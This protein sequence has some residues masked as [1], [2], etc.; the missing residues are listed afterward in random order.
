MGDI[1]SL[2]TMFGVYAVI[3]L[4]GIFLYSRLSPNVE[5]PAISQGDDAPQMSSRDRKL[6]IKMTAVSALDAL[7]GGFIVRCESLQVWARMAV[8]REIKAV[9]S[10]PDVVVTAK[11]PMSIIIA[12]LDAQGRRTPP[13]TIMIAMMTRRRRRPITS[14]FQLAIRLDKALP[15]M[16]PLNTSPAWK[17]L[18]P[19]WLR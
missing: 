16:M 14:P 3:A 19:N 5:P 2:K 15:A 10:P 13:N 8:S 7:G 12:T 18:N 6:I 11:R 17:T 4:A 9:R 1:A